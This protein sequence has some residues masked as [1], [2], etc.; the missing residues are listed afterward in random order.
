[1]N[2]TRWLIVL[3]IVT[4]TWACTQ[5]EVDQSA[6]ERTTARSLD[7]TSPIEWKTHQRFSRYVTAQDGVK[8]AVDVFLPGD[9]IGKSTEPT[10]FPAILLYTPYHRSEINLTTGEVTV[11]YFPAIDF[12]TSRGYAIVTADMRGTGASYGWNAPISKT[13][14]T[15]GKALVDWIAEQPW[16]TG[17][18]GMTGT[19]Y[20]AW[21]QFAT[22]AEKPEALKAIVP[23]HSMWGQDTVRTGGVYAYTFLELWASFTD[24]LNNN[25]V[26][27]NVPFKPAPPVVDED[28]DD[29]ILDEIPLD[30]NGN[31]WFTDDYPWPVDDA[32]P[33]QYSD[34]VQRTEHHY[35]NATSER[36]AHPDGAPG[37]YDAASISA[38]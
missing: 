16:S 10:K 17:K 36:F 9:Y 32:N 19:S 33:P 30:L 3:L 38:A 14:R 34:G 8:L 27:T 22:A 6:T 23:T 24:F 35:F 4:T 20:S 13:L 29:D 2:P 25:V 31:G 11:P 37:N 26:A 15:D 7:G 18:V 5:A 12:F 28:G 1:M 21:S